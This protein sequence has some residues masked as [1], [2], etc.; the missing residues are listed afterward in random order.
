V[1]CVASTLVQGKVRW[2]GG[3]NNV[4]L[5]QLAKVTENPTTDRTKTASARTDR[6]KR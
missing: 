6:G 3:C 5:P 2:R 1:L 4:L